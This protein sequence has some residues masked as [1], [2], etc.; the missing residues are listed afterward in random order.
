MCSGA[1]HPLLM[2]VATDVNFIRRTPV[3]PAFL[4]SSDQIAS[5]TFA[6]FS[7]RAR[8][9]SF[10][11]VCSFGWRDV[12]AATH[13]GYQFRH[14]AAHLAKHLDSLAD[15]IDSATDPGDLGRI[16]LVGFVDMDLKDIARFQPRQ[17]A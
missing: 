8:V 4:R 16:G 6:S 17:P 12:G 15:R 5:A 11:T 14:V 10:S 1:R 9:S 7:A 3:R 2:R 13:A